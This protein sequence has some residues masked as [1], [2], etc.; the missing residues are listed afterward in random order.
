MINNQNKLFLNPGGLS[1][2]VCFQKC[3]VDRNSWM[4]QQKKF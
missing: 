2:L 1:L 3:I 4:F